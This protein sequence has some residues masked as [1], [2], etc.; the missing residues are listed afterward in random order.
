MSSHETTKAQRAFE[1]ASQDGLVN[2]GYS[3]ETFL[4][5]ISA[6]TV[7]SLNTTAPT[8]FDPAPQIIVDRARLLVKIQ[9]NRDFSSVAEKAI[10]ARAPMMTGMLLE[11]FVAYIVCSVDPNWVHL[12]HEVVTSADFMRLP[13]AARAIECLYLQIKNASNSENSSSKK[14]RIEALKN[15]ASVYWY[16]YNHTKG[17]TNWNELNRIMQTE[18]LSEEGFLEYCRKTPI[19]APSINELG[20]QVLLQLPPLQG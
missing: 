12:K 4:R 19:L 8:F 18:N 10:Q 13:Q 20:Q 17:T 9:F 16:R 6:T 3:P 1:Q 2:A 7:L 11:D 5:R 15:V 14:G